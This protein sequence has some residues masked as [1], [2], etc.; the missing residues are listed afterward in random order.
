MTALTAA[1]PTE[2]R[3]PIT[4]RRESDIEREQDRQIDKVFASFLGGFLFKGKKETYGT[5]RVAA[6]CPAP[7]PSSALGGATN[8]KFA[9]FFGDT[10]FWNFRGLLW[11]WKGPIW[12]R[13]EK[14]SSSVISDLNLVDVKPI[15]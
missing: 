8:K 5:P 13:L 10:L 14:C 11:V 3:T 7:D 2:H 15:S 1:P 4:T 9:L 12:V 6:P